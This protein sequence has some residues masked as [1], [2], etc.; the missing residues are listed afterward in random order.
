MRLLNNIAVIFVVD[1]G[2]SKSILYLQALTNI[3]V[4]LI[5]RKTIHD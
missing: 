2:K 1:D 3:A 4:P 5:V